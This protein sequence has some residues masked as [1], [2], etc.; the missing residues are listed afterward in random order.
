MLL[1]HLEHTKHGVLYGFVRDRVFSYNMTAAVVP[2]VMQLESNRFSVGRVSPLEMARFSFSSA[3]RADLSVSATQN[4]VHDI[5]SLE[6]N[7]D[8]E[9]YNRHG[10]CNQCIGNITTMTLVFNT[11]IEQNNFKWSSKPY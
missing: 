1:I 5:K 6:Y 7:N 3:S 8:A 11:T 4:T 2:G 10:S 9:H